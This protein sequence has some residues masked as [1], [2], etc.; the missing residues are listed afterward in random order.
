M[1]GNAEDPSIDEQASDAPLEET[2]PLVEEHAL[3]D[4]PD[5]EG[6]PDASGVKPVLGPEVV[7]RFLSRKATIRFMHT[8][9]R[10]RLKG[11]VP[12]HHVEDVRQQASVRILASKWRPSSE[13]ALPS[14]VARLT[15]FEVFD[16]FRSRATDRKHVDA[17]GDPEAVRGEDES[18][19]RERVEGEKWLIMPWLEKQVAGNP[20]ETEGLAWFREN[21][22]GKTYRQI[23]EAAGVSEN[24][25]RKRIQA[26]KNKYIPRWEKHRWDLENE[27]VRRERFIFLLK[28][29]GLVAAF[30]AAAWL[31]WWLLHPRIEDIRREPEP[32]P[33][34]S[35]SAAPVPSRDIAAPTD[36]GPASP[37]PP[38]PL[39][40]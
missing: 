20:S 33:S 6:K 3:P 30:A 8:I 40:P 27:R 22:N 17:E 39:K 16:F 11:K 13:E 5:A 36:A 12:L 9:V 34:A 7:A 37:K 18:D 23:G 15:K 21:A 24:A 19:V 38:A 28:L 31:A 14:W 2:D 26:I 1:G 4:E 10:E 29:G 32:T 35:A 25:V